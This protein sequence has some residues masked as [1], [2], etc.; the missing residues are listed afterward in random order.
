M[1][2]TTNAAAE[3]TKRP[4]DDA[5]SVGGI[6]EDDAA[7]KPPPKTNRTTRAGS[8]AAASGMTL[9]HTLRPTKNPTFVEVHFNGSLVTVVRVNE[10]VENALKRVR[11]KLGDTCKTVLG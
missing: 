6:D 8:S 10:S 1:D 11:L 7:R 9:P 5:D 4:R 3:S 2:N